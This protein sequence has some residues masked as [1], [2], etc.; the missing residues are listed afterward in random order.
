MLPT[1]I[2]CCFN[3]SRFNVSQS[4]IW[5]WIVVEIVVVVSCGCEKTWG[6]KMKE[7]KKMRKGGLSFTSSLFHNTTWV[8]GFLSISHFLGG[9]IRRWRMSST[10]PYSFYF[11]CR[12]EL[13][14]LA[15]ILAVITLG[16]FW[17]SVND[18]GTY[19]G[20]GSD[21]G[22]KREE[23]IIKNLIFTSG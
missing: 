2:L 17:R 18:P 15:E 6:I 4:E 7:R 21:D 9:G 3:I 12:I 8:N 23:E 20:A 16:R 5:N 22:I 1:G 19:F 11:T 14:K 13:S 10:I